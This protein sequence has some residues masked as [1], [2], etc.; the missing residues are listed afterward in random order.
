M[1]PTRLLRTSLLIAAISLPCAGTAWAGA[2]KDLDE[3]PCV[4]EMVDSVAR[5]GWVGISM[6][7][8]DRSWILTEVVPGGP[9][10]AVGLVKGDRLLA[11]NGVAMVQDNEKEL[12]KIYAG[13]VPGAKLVYTIERDGSKREITVTLGRLPGKMMALMLGQYLIESYEATTGES[14]KLHGRPA[15]PKPPAPEAPKK[16]TGG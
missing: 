1:L 11:M 13:M 5:R 16:P 8:D 9:A 3:C 14:V 15:S 2:C 4:L 10:Q 12:A 6:E 7:R